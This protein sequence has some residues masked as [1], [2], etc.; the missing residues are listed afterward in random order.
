MVVANWGFGM[1]LGFR[2]RKTAVDDD[3]CAGV[4]DWGIMQPG[5][6]Q[7]ALSAGVVV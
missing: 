2:P 1:R 3:H 7:F 6:A 5:K 4:G